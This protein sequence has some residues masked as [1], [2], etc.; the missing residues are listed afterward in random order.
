MFASPQALKSALAE[1]DAE[2][3]ALLGLMDS[4]PSPELAAKIR[5]LQVLIWKLVKRLRRMQEIEDEGSGSGINWRGFQPP[6]ANFSIAAF[7]GWLRSRGV[8]YKTQE[9][10]IKPTF[11]RLEKPFPTE[12]E[13]DEYRPPEATPEPVSE[14][15]EPDTSLDY[16]FNP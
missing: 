16:L 6:P 5:Q 1:L 11:V 3:S 8:S 7:L 4:D 14:D 2:L 10:L 15:P 12:A 9:T 13:L